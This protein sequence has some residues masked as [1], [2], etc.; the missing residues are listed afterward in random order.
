MRGAASLTAP[1]IGRYTRRVARHPDVV[2]VGGGIIGLAVAREA[3]RAGLAVRLLERGRPGCEAS[4][5]AAGMLSAQADAARDEPLL[6]LGLASRDLYP[7]FAGAVRDESGV[8]PELRGEGTILL[9]RSSRDLEAIQRAAAF[10][11]GLGLPAERLAAE[12]LRR[13]EPG[14]SPEY[15]GGVLLPRDVSIDNVRL[16]RGLAVAA[17]RAGAEVEI[18]STVTGLIVG[19]GTVTGVTTLSGRVG[20]GAVVVAAGAWSGGIAGEGVPAPA[21]HPVRGQIVCLDGLRA[22]FR[23]VLVEGERYLVRRGD[24]RVL[25]GSTAERCGFDRS[26][27]GGALAALAVAAVSIVPA[28]AAAPFRAAWAGLRP[29]SDDGLPLIGPAP[30]RGLL[31]A[32][33]HFRNGILLAPITAHLLARL[34]TGAPPGIDLAPFDP[35]RFA[36]GSRTV[37]GG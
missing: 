32:C 14:L 34:F 11:R 19:G 17:E 30:T 26:V 12:D 37:T 29:A 20:A 6:R 31:Y 4:G 27:T 23:H 8:D 5:A 9:A 1:P 25:A 35:A 24:G 13:L 3:A 2:V 36:A 33:G 15:A 21:S 18:G 7:E 16:V 28:L 22:P 10:Q